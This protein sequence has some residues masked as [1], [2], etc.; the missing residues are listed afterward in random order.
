[1]SE[2]RDFSQIKHAVSVIPLYAAKA[3]MLNDTIA[4]GADI[5]RIRY[6]QEIQQKREQINPLE[7]SSPLRLR[8]HD[9]FKSYD[10]IGKIIYPKKFSKKI[11]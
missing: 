1:M 6:N 4:N 5:I 3:A 11:S 7:A 2:I 8:N 10:C 9:Q